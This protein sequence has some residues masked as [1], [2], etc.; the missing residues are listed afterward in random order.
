MV[1]GIRGRARPALG[2]VVPHLHGR[3]PRGAVVRDGLPLQDHQRLTVPWSWRRPPGADLAG[4]MIALGG[5][6]APAPDP[7]TMIQPGRRP[8]EVS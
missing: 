3:L 4:R 1:G 2:Q 6:A 5:A 7:L 8:R